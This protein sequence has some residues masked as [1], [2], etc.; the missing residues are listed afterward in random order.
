MCKMDILKHY[1]LVY[2]GSQESV[3]HVEDPLQPHRPPHH[4]H[5][6]R[7]HGDAEVEIVHVPHH[8]FAV[9]PSS[10][11]HGSAP[12]LSRDDLQRLVAQLSGEHATCGGSPG[13]LS[14]PWDDSD[15]ELYAAPASTQ[16][17]QP[18]VA[19]TQQTCQEQV[20]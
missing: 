9:S 19:V 15:A 1:G 7:Q 14:P 10:R 11:H 20:P 12:L 3:L 17:D 8:P 16:Q 18:L 2:T 4:L 6:M 13:S 5:P